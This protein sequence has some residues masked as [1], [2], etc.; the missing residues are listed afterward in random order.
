MWFRFIE[1][2]LYKDYYTSEYILDRCSKNKVN[3]DSEKRKIDFR[4]IE[5]IQNTKIDDKIDLKTKNTLEIKD[6]T[7]VQ[8]STGS[9][10]E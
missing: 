6:E 9:I 2:E 5:N 7:E 4:E 10:E 3:S 8:N 1:P